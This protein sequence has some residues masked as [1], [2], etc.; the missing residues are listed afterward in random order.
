VTAGSL[1]WG[2]IAPYAVFAA[3]MVGLTVYRIL[4]A[5]VDDPAKALMFF[6]LLFGAL[7]VVAVVGFLR[8]RAAASTARG[9]LAALEEKFPG[10]AFSIFKSGGLQEDVA[11]LVPAMRGASWNAWTLYAVLT[12]DA[13][14]ITIW[15][16]SREQAVVTAQLDRSAVSVAE[17]ATEAIRLV[18]VR[19]LKLEVQH[20]GAALS[21]T[22]APA[23]VGKLLFRAATDDSFSAFESSLGIAIVAVPES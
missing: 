10:H 19:A 2:L 13:E 17:T 15:D 8:Y 6:G 9:L 5:S 14:S 4:R 3:A 18:K 21:V 12:V 7:V 11:T 16:G 22:F 20:E 23:V 1:R